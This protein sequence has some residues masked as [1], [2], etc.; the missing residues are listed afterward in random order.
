LN[1][2]V[3]EISETTSLLL[4]GQDCDVVLERIWDPKTLIADIRDTLVLI[5]IIRFG[6]SFV[7]NI[8]EVLVVGEDDMA[9]NIEELDE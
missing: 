3:D 2:C 5:P 8:V 9:S 6:K 4:F 1:G 7:D